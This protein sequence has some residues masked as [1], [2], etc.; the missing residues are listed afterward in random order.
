MP[1]IHDVLIG[2]VQ[3]ASGQSDMAFR[4]QSAQDAANEIALARYPAVRVL[5]VEKP[6]SQVPCED[7]RGV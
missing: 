1:R 7:V 2:E 5:M 3:L 6:F 4:L